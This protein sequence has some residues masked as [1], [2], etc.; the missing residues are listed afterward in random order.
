MTYDIVNLKT[1]EVVGETKRL[2]QARSVLRAIVSSGTTVKI[3]GGMVRV[4]S[5]HQ[6][7]FGIFHGSKRC[8]AVAQS[9]TMPSYLRD[10][11]A[12]QGMGEP[13]NSERE[14]ARD[15]DVFPD[16]GYNS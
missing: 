14:D 15:S 2:T 8:S 16:G 7:P 4:R 6:F 13:N 11:R 12:A 10:D 3:E 1:G 5:Y 9:R